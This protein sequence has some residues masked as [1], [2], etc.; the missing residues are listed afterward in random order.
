MIENQKLKSLLPI[1][2]ILG[3]AF[4]K[5]GF[6][7]VL[8]YRTLRDS[9]QIVRIIPA[10]QATQVEHI[11]LPGSLTGWHEAPL[12]S[13]ANGYLHEWFVDIGYHV[14]KGDILATV[15]RPELDAKFSAAKDFLEVMSANDKLA[16][17]TKNRWNRL[18]LTDSVSRQANDNKTYEA[19][20][21]S[22]AKNQAQSNVNKLGAYVDFEKII[23]PFD[24][25]ISDR[26][27]DN[28]RLINV[29]SFPMQTE[30]LFKIVQ[31]NPLR[32]Y[33][34][35]PQTYTPRLKQNMIFELRLN[36]F[37]GQ[38]FKAKLLKTAEAIDPI[39]LTLQSEFEVYNDD[40]T[41]LPGSYTT[42]EFFIPRDKAD[43][44]LPVNTLLFQANGLQVAV[45]NKENQIELRSVNIAKDYGDK[46]VIDTGIKVGER[47]IINPPDTLMNKELVNVI[48]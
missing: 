2:I 19:L 8:K 27:T 43:I 33:V 44:I 6:Y 34:N 36:E 23:A 29:G 5:I 17:I 7:F 3:F 45:V 11:S 30:P 10:K 26:R 16:Q 9:V 37:P 40:N 32:L 47:V 42:V 39:T 38:K 28:G 31:T 12:Y 35:I 25:V 14:K 15:E 46:V 22:N 21:I 41:L 18:V 1:V 24:G 13:R 20:A 4:Y 48:A